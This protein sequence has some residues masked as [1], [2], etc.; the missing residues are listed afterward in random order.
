MQILLTCFSNLRS[1]Q[2]WHSSWKLDISRAKLE[3]NRLDP[4]RRHG[5]LVSKVNSTRRNQNQYTARVDGFVLKITIPVDIFS[6]QDH[7]QYVTN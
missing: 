4:L 3:R 7:I 1:F 6:N 5:M 2:W